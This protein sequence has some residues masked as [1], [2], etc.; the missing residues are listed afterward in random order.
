MIGRRYSEGLHQ[1]IEAKENVVVRNENKTYA[2]ITFQNE[3]AR[4]ENRLP[5]RYLFDGGGQTP[6]DS[7]RDYRTPRDGATHSRR[8]GYGRKVGRNF[9]LAYQKQGQTQHTQR[10]KP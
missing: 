1:A 8:Y 7:R 10:Q 2:T 4:T 6:R 9:P 3:Q 5:G